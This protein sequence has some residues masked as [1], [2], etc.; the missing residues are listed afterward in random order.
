MPPPGS[1]PPGPPAPP[2]TSTALALAFQLPVDLKSVGYEPGI[3]VDSTGALYI[4]A[5][6][7]LNRPD[8]WPYPGSFFA[9]SRDGGATWQAPTSPGQVHQ[10]F[11]GDEGDIG[12]D[13]RGWVYFVDTYAADNHLHVW[14]D[15]GKTWQLSQPIQKTTGADD[16]PWVTAQGSGIVHYLGNN[17]VEVNGGRHWYYR[18]TDAGVTWSQGAPIA[19]N[20]WSHIDAQRSGKNVYIANEGGGAGAPGDILVY[21]S[22]DQGASFGSAVAAGKRA[23]PGREYPIV[24]AAEDDV[25]WVLWSD[26]GTAA[27]CADTGGA[28]PTRVFVART[29]DAGATWQSWDATGALRAYIDYPT[30]AAGPN[31]TVAVAFYATTDLPISASSEWFLYAGMARALDATPEFRFARAAPEPVYKGNDLHSLHDFFEIAIGP[32][33]TLHIGYQHTEGASSEDGLRR[34]FYA[35][36]SPVAGSAS[37]S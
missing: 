5:H 26:C 21:A 19:G 2:A 18:S 17:G 7:D 32:D 30:I 6:K 35:Q 22:H 27:N 8:T 12:V 9:V 34:I 33:E 37:A 23:G 20:G 11:V 10:L 13:A 16:R 3:A 4:T 1:P 24:S 31:G 25:A 28:D 15:Q 29:D 14:S 36:G